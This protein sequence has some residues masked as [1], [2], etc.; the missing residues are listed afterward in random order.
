[1]IC[2]SDTSYRK[3][4][5]RFISCFHVLTYNTAVLTQEAILEEGGKE[6]KTFEKY[7]TTN[8][9]VS[10][11]RRYSRNILQWNKNNMNSMKMINGD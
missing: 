11:K 1:M 6:K 9:D 8:Y 3:D 7:K 5:E 4:T 2:I 10:G